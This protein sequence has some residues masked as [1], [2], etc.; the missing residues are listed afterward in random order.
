MQCTYQGKV[1]IGLAGSIVTSLALNERLEGSEA[2][3]SLL[4]KHLAGT[5]GT[6]EFATATPIQKNSKWT[7]ALCRRTKGGSL[8]VAILT[9]RRFMVQITHSGPCLD[10][11]KS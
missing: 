5:A 9:I 3:D 2:A 8:N 6:M 7:P 11:Q 1:E 10:T 4:S